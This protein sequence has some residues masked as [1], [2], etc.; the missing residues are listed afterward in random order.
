MRHH[1]THAQLITSIKCILPC[2]FLSPIF[3]HNPN[4]FTIPFNW[5]QCCCWE[6]RMT[7]PAWIRIC[8]STSD[9]KCFITPFDTTR[10]T[11]TS[12][13]EFT[14]LFFDTF[15]TSSTIVSAIN[16]FID[17]SWIFANNLCFNSPSGD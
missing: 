9:L 8:S 13:S 16:T 2:D 12:V 3:K 7:K 6:I 15:S 14:R 1:Y 17:I 10:W 4:S 5:E 11:L